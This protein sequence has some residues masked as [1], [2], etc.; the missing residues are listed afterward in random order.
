VGQ[1][2]GLGGALSPADRSK[3]AGCEALPDKSLLSRSFIQVWWSGRLRPR[4]W[5]LAFDW[6]ATPTSGDW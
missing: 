6:I 5:A 2:R 4:P 1:A 3:E